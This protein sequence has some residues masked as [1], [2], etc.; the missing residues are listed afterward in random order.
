MGYLNQSGEQINVDIFDAMGR[1]VY[2]HPSNFI[3]GINNL[4]IDATFLPPGIYTLRIKG[5]TQK[6]YIA[7]LLIQ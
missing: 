1:K 5:T 7:R 3:N 2:S 6:P 4:D